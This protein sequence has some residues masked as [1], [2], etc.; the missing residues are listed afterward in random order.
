MISAPA[1]VF[2]YRES[3]PLHREIFRDFVRAIADSGHLSVCVAPEGTPLDGERI[4]HFE[5]YATG[6]GRR[7][8]MADAVVR[9][10]ERFEVVRLISTTED[11][12]IDA[13]RMR[14]RHAIPGTDTET[15][16][17]FRDKNAM[18]A[19][20]AEL[21]FRTPRSCIPHTRATLEAFA[22]GVGYPVVVKP[23][24]GISCGRTAKLS[25]PEEL[26]ELWPLVQPD[27][28]DMRAE[29]YVEG[30][31]FHIDTIVRD[32]RTVFEAV[33]AYEVTLLDHY[34]HRSIGS[35]VSAAQ[36]SPLEQR[37]LAATRK[38]ITGLGL[39]TGI[40]HTEFF[41]TPQGE[42]VFGESGARMGG[43]Y[44]FP[45][46]RQAFGLSLPYMWVRAELDPGYAPAPDRRR[47]AAGDLLWTDATGVVE[48]I[49]GEKELLALP[50]V[51][52]AQVWKRTGTWIAAPTEAGGQ[53][54]GFTVVGGDSPD[55]ARANAAAT[56]RRF[57]VMAGPGR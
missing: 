14:E 24:D 16:I 47:D 5:P 9:A 13:A 48:D 36:D 25:S 52:E 19:R 51:L 3:K 2:L 49:T 18:V 28:H 38:L 31:Q 46:Y 10:V 17:H 11:D 1:V 53:G 35:V 40:A 43:G 27:R 20:A 54:L 50:D 57:Q 33:A 4:D 26:A 8:A 29:Q 41:V 21:G 23:Y 34:R 32:G 39:R 7:E 45:L 6:T 15:A 56:L 12:V 44:I 30:R 37:L 42:L 22:S 55:E